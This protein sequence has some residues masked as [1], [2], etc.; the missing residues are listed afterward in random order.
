MIKPVQLEVDRDKGDFHY[1]TDYE[2]DAGIGLNEDVVRYISEVKGEEE[3][4]KDYRLK[5]LETFEKNLCRSI[6]R[7][8]TW[9]TFI[10]RKS[11]TIS[12][13]DSVPVGL[14]MKFPMML[15]KLSN[16]S[17]FRNRKGSS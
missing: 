6:G 10:S 7:Q 9:K 2:Y 12:P 1:E 17:E 16:A 13:K 4:V 3:W 14:G 15:R 8:G 11:A 5:A